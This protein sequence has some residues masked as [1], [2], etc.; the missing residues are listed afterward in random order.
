VSTTRFGLP[1]TDTPRADKWLTLVNKASGLCLHQTVAIA[2][3]AFPYYPSKIGLFQW[4][5]VLKFLQVFCEFIQHGK[6]FWCAVI[7]LAITFLLA[8]LQFLKLVFFAL[9]PLSLISAT[10]NI[11]IVSLYF[12]YPWFFLFAIVELIITSYLMAVTTHIA[13]IVSET[14]HQGLE[15]RVCLTRRHRQSD[16]RDLNVDVIFWNYRVD[17]EKVSRLSSI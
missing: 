5:V 2:L 10:R 16:V 12:L 15:H 13:M 4:T 14:S 17:V 8:L 3:H 11:M 6:E 9:S 1:E 7:M